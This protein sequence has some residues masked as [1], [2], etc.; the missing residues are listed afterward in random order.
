MRCGRWL[1]RALVDGPPGP[2]AGD[3]L[4]GIQLAA[5]GAADGAGAVAQADAGLGVG[6]TITLLA[7]LDDAVATLVAVARVVGQAG[8][9]TL[10]LAVGGAGFD[11][12]DLVGSDHWARRSNSERGART[13]KATLWAGSVVLVHAGDD[14]R[15]NP[16]RDRVLWILAGC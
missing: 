3:A 10:E 6:R 8:G 13:P 12:V 16:I 5:G 11:E 15:C 9:L 2:G 7:A 14:V 4:A 1:Q